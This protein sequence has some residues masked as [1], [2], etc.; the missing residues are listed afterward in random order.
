MNFY[1]KGKIPTALIGNLNVLYQ[2]KKYS[3]GK[4]DVT[5]YVITTYMSWLATALNQ[6]QSTDQTIS[7][8]GTFSAFY[9]MYYAFSLGL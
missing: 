8:E 5:G 6:P 1:F 7:F 9:Y 4:K 2:E 3:L